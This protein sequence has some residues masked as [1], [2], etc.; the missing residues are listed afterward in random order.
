MVVKGINFKSLPFAGFLAGYIMYFVDKWFVGFLGL[1]GAFPGTDSAWWMLEHH[2]DSI[3][4][5]FIFAWPALYNI[6][7][8]GGWLKGL[9]F[10]FLWWILLT[11]VSFITGALGAEMFQQMAFSA[12]TVISGIILHLIYGFFLGV[13]YVPAEPS[14]AV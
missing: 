3:M 1:L 7:P 6:L 8:G 10:G 11:I 9:I 4:I 5:A 13:L 2:I 12:T 14:K